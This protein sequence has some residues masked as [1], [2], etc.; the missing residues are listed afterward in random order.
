MQICFFG[1]YDKYYSR[2]QIILKGLAINHVLVVEVHL[3]LP[4]S[5]ISEEE[6]LTM[7]IMIKRLLRKLKLIPIVFKNLGNIR[8]SDLIF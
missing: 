8:H 6:H 3:D 5:E 4:K 2:N 1:S 7:S